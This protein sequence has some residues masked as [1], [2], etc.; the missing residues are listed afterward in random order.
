MH[1]SITHLLLI[2]LLVSAAGCATPLQRG[3]DAFNRGEYD[4]AASHWNQLAAEGDPYAQYN[5]GLLWESG[6][7][8]TPR[9]PSEAGN[10]YERSAGQGYVPAMV[11]LAHLK[12]AWGED[13]EANAWLTFAARWGSSE[14]AELLRERG[15]E[16]PHADLLAEQQYQQALYESQRAQS[17]AELNDGL[18][19]LTCALVGGS[20]APSAPTTNSSYSPAPRSTVS[21]PSEEECTSDFS[22]GMGYTC[23]KPPLHTVG[24]CMRSVDEMGIQQFDLPKLD[25]VGPNMRIEGQCTF[26]T[27]CPVGFRCDPT[28]RACVKN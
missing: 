20:C 14:A 10:W 2:V 3:V 9:N 28:Y 24:V 6:L 5:L 19:V 22:C 16:V 21:S 13:D 11:R 25:S 4:V 27:D 23:V 1:K 15:Q 26:T 12:S 7:G 17:S 18:R 8:S